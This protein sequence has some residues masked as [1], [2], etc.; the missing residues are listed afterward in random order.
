MKDGFILILIIAIML[1]DIDSI[2]FLQIKTQIKKL[3]M[4]EL[5][6]YVHAIARVLNGFKRR[7]SQLKDILG[8]FPHI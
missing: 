2:K 1:E 6:H 4:K 3:Y 7:G 5:F 8:W